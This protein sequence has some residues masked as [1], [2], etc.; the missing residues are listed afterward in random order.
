MRVSVRSTFKVGDTLTAT[1]AP[2]DA[3]N[4]VS[5]QWYADDVAINGANLATYTVAETDLGKAIKVVVTDDA[6]KEFPS[7][8]TSTVIPDLYRLTETSGLHIMI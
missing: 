7:E 5:Y 3:T 8:P 1:V 6:G 2:A 4:V